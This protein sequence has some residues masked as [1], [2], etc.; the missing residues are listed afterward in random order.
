MSYFIECLLRLLMYDLNQVT[1]ESVTHILIN[2]SELL[3]RKIFH[4]IFQTTAS[5]NVK[6]ITVLE[7]LKP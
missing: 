4:N 7:A 1:E 5:A 2:T 6:N 3:E